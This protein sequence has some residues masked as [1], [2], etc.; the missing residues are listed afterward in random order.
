MPVLKVKN[1][2]VWKEIAGASEHTHSE[3]AYA[4]D[5]SELEAKFTN[6]FDTKVGDSS[7]AEQIEVA[8][9]NKASLVTKTVTLSTSGWT[10]K[11]KTISVDGV[12]VNNTVIVSYAPGSYT[13]YSECGIRC[14]SQGT[15]ILTFQCENIPSGNIAVNVAILT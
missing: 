14:V 6:E 5:V 1:N 13:I 11:Q 3:Y 9:S 15:G 12:T 10:N 2:G 7:V 8:I 4:S